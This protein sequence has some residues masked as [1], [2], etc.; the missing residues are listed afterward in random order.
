MKKLLPLIVLASACR[1]MDVEMDGKYWVWLAANSSL[2]VDEDSVG[3]IEEEASTI[4][5][6]TGRGFDY[7]TLEWD[8]TYVG[9]RTLE[10]AQSGLY[11]GG[12]PDGFCERE[13]PLDRNTPYVASCRET[14]E[15]VLAQC[16][17]DGDP[18]NGIS[19][20]QEATFH[21]FLFEDGVYFLDGDVEPTR[22][23]AYIH[24]ENDLQINMMQKIQNGQEFR[25]V[26]SIATDFAPTL[27][28]S[29]GD[30][31]SIQAVDGDWIEQWS[32]DEDGKSIYYLNAGAFQ[33]N[34]AASDSNNT[35]WYNIT[36]WSSGFGF[37]NYAGEEFY[38]V[39]GGFGNYNID[40]DGNPNYNGQFYTFANVGEAGF[41]A[42]TEAE[43]SAL[44]D[45]AEAEGLSLPLSPED[46]E[47]AATGIGIWDSILERR[48]ELAAEAAVWQQELRIAGANDGS[49]E[50][51]NPMCYQT[52][53]ET[54]DW[55]SVDD[56]LA[57]LDGWMEMHSSW[58]RFDSGSKLEIGGSA[59]GD[60]QILFRGELTQSVI[61]VKG[62][63]SIEEIKEDRWSY[64]FLE[65]EKRADTS[66][67]HQGKQYCEK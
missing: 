1:P 17:G 12:D 28:L 51:D 41:L 29:D 58:V 9:P 63:F 61:L 25:F 32:V 56:S 20:F 44:G 26:V 43:H 42:V 31:S 13:T 35:F 5:D 7:D 48:E 34:E 52:K 64:G 55:R 4:I 19:G 59:S 18:D 49:C 3:D 11:F 39:P 16:A 67:E 50:G 38:S 60:Y 10:E 8:E 6:C 66:D 40:G 27:C 37:A 21:T 15:A 53:I 65:D 2:V 45:Y 23:E 62:T 46:F 24:G 47:T 36:D 14:A 30:G 33:V 54:N 22:T 57:G